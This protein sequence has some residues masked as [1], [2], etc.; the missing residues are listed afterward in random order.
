MGFNRLATKGEKYYLLP[1]QNEKKLLTTVRKKINRLPTW[2]AII[3]IC[4][5]KEEIR[6][7]FCIFSSLRSNHIKG[8][9][10]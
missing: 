7:A 4:L 6:R 2:T 9:K 1:G 3:D 5:Q 10:L 8:I